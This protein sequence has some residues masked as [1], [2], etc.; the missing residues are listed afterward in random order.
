MKKNIKTTSSIMLILTVVTQALSASE[1]PDFLLGSWQINQQNNYEVWSRVDKNHYQG[2]VIQIM[3]G[4]KITKENLQLELKN[5]EL[6]YQAQV[7]DQNDGK[8]IDFVG[9]MADN[10]TFKVANLNHDFPQLIKYKQQSAD[11]IM[12]K[13]MDKNGEGF[14]QELNRKALPDTIPDWFFA[15]MEA[16]VGRW[17]TDNS[18]YQSANETFDTYVIEWQWGIGKHSIT[19]RLF[20]I[21]DGKE[22]PD[23]WHFRQYWDNLTQKAMVQQFG[24]GGVMG[25]GEMR[26]LN[27]IQSELIQTFST[28]AGS[29]W[30]GKH[31]NELNGNEFKTQSLRMGQ[32]GEW[33][34][35]REYI[36]HKQ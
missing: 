21:A 10:K 2:Q 7:I 16:H 32:D 17:E 12:A 25:I 33:Q 5:G 4:K 28:P 13:V 9:Q 15:D 22:S 18:K 11:Q 27:D 1:M 20:G 23:F 35:D 30:P 34:A 31:V 19:G 6:H 3:G 14:T 29:Q 24:N 8:A 26:Y 36:W